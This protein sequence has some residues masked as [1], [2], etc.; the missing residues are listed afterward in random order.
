MYGQKTTRAD[1]GLSEISA[2]V[3][4]LPVGYN[5]GERRE[6]NGDIYRL[7]YNM[8]NQQVLPG[9]LVCANIGSALAAG[10]YTCTISTVTEVN[11]TVIGAVKHATAT[12]GT[13]FWA[14]TETIVNSTTLSGVTV[15]A[16]NGVYIL[17]AANGQITNG[18][19]TACIGY[20]TASAKFYISLENKKYNV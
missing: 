7:C 4:S 18:T 17:P 9:Y 20:S 15:I 10:P 19:V 8:S 13:Y 3:S 11:Q 14:L 5:M 1:A 16:S 6:Y 12:T 2:V